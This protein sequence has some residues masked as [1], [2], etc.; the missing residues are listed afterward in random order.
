MDP[1]LLL[2]WFLFLDHAVSLHPDGEAREPAYPDQEVHSMSRSGSSH[3][4]Q[5]YICSLVLVPSIYPDEHRISV[6]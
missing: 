2:M 4:T 5:V 3:I 1:H 6:A